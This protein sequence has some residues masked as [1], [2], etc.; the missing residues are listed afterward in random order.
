MSTKLVNNSLVS[1]HAQCAVEAI[2]LA[3]KLNLINDVNDIEVLRQTLSTS[4]YWFNMHD[5]LIC[6][7]LIFI[8]CYCYLR[9]YSKIQDIILNDYKIYFE[10]STDPRITSSTAPLRNLQKDMKCVLSD[11]I[12]KSG[13]VDDP[14]T[15]PVTK[16]A[17]HKIDEACGDAYKLKDSGFVTLLEVL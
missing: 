13:N 17:T 9:G 12:Q 7:C 4:W 6:L 15:F 11:I 8:Y 14:K 5:V 1:M 2:Q 16:L 3:N 10:K